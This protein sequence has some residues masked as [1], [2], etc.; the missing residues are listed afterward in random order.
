MER[1]AALAV[2][3]QH[4]RQTKHLLRQRAKTPVVELDRDEIVALDRGEEIVELDRE[5][6]VELEH[7]WAKQQPSVD[8]AY[9]WAKAPHLIDVRERV[10]LVDQT[11][12]TV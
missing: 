11:E 6:I 5:E 7:G 4:K 3:T 1:A 9:R 10:E 2:W 8:M 12:K